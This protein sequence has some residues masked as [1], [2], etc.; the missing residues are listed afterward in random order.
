VCLKLLDVLTMKDKGLADVG[1]S[2]NSGCTKSL[3]H[4]FLFFNLTS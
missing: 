3:S 1:K 4:F 2:A